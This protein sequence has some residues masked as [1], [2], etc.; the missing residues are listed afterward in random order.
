MRS[1]F[2]IYDAVQDFDAASIKHEIYSV[3]VPHGGFYEHITFLNERN[4][5]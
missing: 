3:H 1:S 4:L 5:V 2:S